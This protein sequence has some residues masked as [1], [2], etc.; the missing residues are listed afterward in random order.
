MTSISR[1]IDRVLRIF[2]VLSLLV[3]SIV[4]H[5]AV[6]AQNTFAL[7]AAN[8]SVD[9]GG[10]VAPDGSIPVLC[11]AGGDTQ[12]P[13]KI[14]KGQ[15]DFCRN[16]SVAALPQPSDLFEACALSV[17]A[18]IFFAAPDDMSWQAVYTNASPRGPPPRNQ[19]L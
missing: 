7:T 12:G 2:C 18:R 9:L 5:P 6:F 1:P 8:G 15:C 17:T 19:T 16:V 4:H 10:Y 13:V 3:V 14:N 11:I